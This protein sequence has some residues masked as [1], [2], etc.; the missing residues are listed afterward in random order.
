MPAGFKG[1]TTL[2]FAGAFAG[3]LLGIRRK[4]KQVVLMLLAFGLIAGLSACGGKSGSGGP[5]VRQP[6]NATITVTGTSGS[7]SASINLN[8][9]INH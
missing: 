3:V 5:V 8:L 1:M 2:T 4:R 7:Q 6:T 9:T